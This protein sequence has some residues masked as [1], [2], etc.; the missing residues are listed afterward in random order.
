MFRNI[1]WDVDGTLFDT[2]PSIARAFKA[3]LKDFGK[4]ASLDWIH[5]LARK[6]LGECLSTLA[7]TFALDEKMLGQAFGQ[8]YDAVKPEAQ[9][10]FPGVVAVCDY[11]CAIGGKNVIVTHRGREGTA[12]LL[13]A[14]HMAQYFA[15]FLARD[16]G[17]PKKPHPAAFEA[18]LILHNLRPGETMAVGDREID[19]LAGQ[20]AG[21]FSCLFRGEAEDVRADLSVGSFDE[22]YDYLVSRNGEPP[23]APSHPSGL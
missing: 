23:H 7:G 22:L 17:Y 16:D 20:A 10:P 11:I 19:V 4:E 3:A 1:I 2:Y 5:E 14:N 18:A 8:R 12:E 13:A 15:G 21:L 9:P 6:S